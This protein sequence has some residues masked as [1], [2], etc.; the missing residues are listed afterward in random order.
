MNSLFVDASRS[1]RII[2]LQTIPKLGKAGDVKDVSP[3]FFR[4]FL[5]PKNLAQPATREAL[6]QAEA[7]RK[8]AEELA[9]RELELAQAM[10]KKLDGLEFVFKLRLDPKGEA[11]GSVNAEMIKDELDKL[12]YPIEKHNVRIDEPILR[13]SGPGS[14]RQSRLGIRTIGEHPVKI[15]LA[16]GLEAELRVIVE[17]V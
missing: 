3:G 8:K 14:R 9:Q 11:Y 17:P 5:S 13:P 1:M 6:K 7:L 15:E 4:N 12:G 2:L 16:H 10:V